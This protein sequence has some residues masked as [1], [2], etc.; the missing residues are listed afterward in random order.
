MVQLA[1]R[2]EYR[3]PEPVEI[4]QVPCDDR[5]IVHR[6]GGGD[7]RVGYQI[8][9]LAVHQPGP[10]PEGASIHRQ[11]TVRS[12]DTI[13]PGLD[14][15]GP[16]RIVLSGIFHSRL[17]LSEGDRRDKNFVC[18]DLREPGNKTGM[19]PRATQL[20]NHVRIEQVHH[21]SLAGGRQRHR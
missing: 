21:F 7:H 2:V 16:S 9:R 6:G 11:D 13:D 20:G 5:Q 14:R 1:E 10:E 18:A 15:F 19:R 12:S 3:Y 4:A 8:G 17:K